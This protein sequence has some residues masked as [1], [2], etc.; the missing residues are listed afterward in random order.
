MRE[1][2]ALPLELFHLPATLNLRTL[3]INK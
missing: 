2:K 1:N 3:A